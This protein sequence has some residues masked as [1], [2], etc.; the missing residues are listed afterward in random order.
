MSKLIT[1]TITSLTVHF[2][3]VDNKQLVDYCIKVMDKEPGPREL[4]KMSKE[5]GKTV[6]VSEIEKNNA[7]YGMPVEQFMELATQIDKKPAT[8]PD[9]STII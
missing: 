2:A 3:I 5:A 7:T 6:V 4:A 8:N 9:F 1:R